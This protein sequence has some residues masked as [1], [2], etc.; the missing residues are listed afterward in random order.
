VASGRHWNGRQHARHLVKVELE[1]DTLDQ[2][3]EALEVGVDAV[4]LENMT[5]KT[6]RRG[7]IATRKLWFKVSS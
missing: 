2:L 7:G 4:L 6:T 5:P 3:A 1:V